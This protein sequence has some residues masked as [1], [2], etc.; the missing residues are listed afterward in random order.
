MN[1]SGN[2]DC[3]IVPVAEDCF[4]KDGYLLDSFGICIQP[5]ECGCTLPDN[6][7]VIS[8][9]QV[10]Y[11]SDCKSIYRCNQSLSSVIIEE[12]QC[13]NNSICVPDASGT[14]Q[15]KCASG[16][17]GNGVSCVTD[18]CLATPS[19]C[20]PG[21]L[22]TSTSGNATCTCPADK[23]GNPYSRCCSKLKK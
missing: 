2:Y 16:F 8:I 21:A 4:C 6:S 1:P 20:G 23:P 5:S 15:C 18:P 13:S 17:F 14:P 9:G 3:G 11:S 19:P 10:V 22:C 12:R 7:T